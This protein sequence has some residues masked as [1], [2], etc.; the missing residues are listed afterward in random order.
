MPTGMPITRVTAPGT[1]PIYDSATAMW[2]TTGTG[3]A[4]KTTTWRQH[5]QTVEMMYERKTQFDPTDG[6]AEFN[7]LDVAWTAG[8]EQEIFYANAS[9]GD[10]LQQQ[11]FDLF[12]DSA[13]GGFGLS[14][15]LRTTAAGV[16]RRESRTGD[17]EAVNSQQGNL[18]AGK[19]PG[20][21]VLDGGFDSSTTTPGTL[22]DMLMKI[23]GSMPNFELWLCNL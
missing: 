11:T 3:D 14:G 9:S 7:Y 22:V 8:T 15:A 13:S 18:I 10:Y 4:T 16:Y 1:S 21:F 19:L 2:A 6:G 12:S 23:Q 20:A 17:V 5:I